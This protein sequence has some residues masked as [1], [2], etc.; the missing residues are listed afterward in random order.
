MKKN[1]KLIGGL[2]TLALMGVTNVYAQ[3]C[4][5]LEARINEA[6][7]GSTVNA[8]SCDGN[9]SIRNNIT[10]DLYGSTINTSYIE[11]TGDVKIKDS[12]GNGKIVGSTSGS[13]SAIGVEGKLTL[14]SGEIES[15]EFAILAT[16]GGS[17]TVNGGS[18]KARYA[19]LSGN[20]T[21]GAMEFVVNG[22]EITSNEGPAVYMP[23]PISYTMTGGKVNGGLL[24]R[25]GI[26]NVSGGNIVAQENKDKLD[27]LKQYYNFSGYVNYPDAISVIA[28]TYNTDI[29]G[30]TNKLEM[31][32][33]GGELS[34]N[35]GS[36]I[37]I[38]DFGK[39][40]QE[41]SVNI[42]GGSFES[43]NS[44]RKAYQIL[45]LNDLGV[46]NPASG[47]NNPSFMGDVKTTIT[48]GSFN[49]DVSQFI[50]EDYIQENGVVKKKEEETDKPFIP[51]GNLIVNAPIIESGKEVDVITVG[52][53]NTDDA[54]NAFAK[55]IES[56]GIDTENK[57]VSVDVKVENVKEIDIIESQIQNMKEA[58][59]KN[60]PNAKVAGYFDITL[61]LLEME[62]NVELGTLTKLDNKVKFN[63]A[64]PNDL[65]NVQG[66]YTRTYYIVRFHDNKSEIITANLN[67]DKSSVSFETDKF[68]TY[69]LIYKDTKEEVSVPKTF[70][71]ISSYLIIGGISL[72]S[73]FGL[74]KFLK[75]RN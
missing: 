70:D 5:S 32:I 57:K 19:A 50:G 11:I 25:M 34:S 68:S 62:N 7:A 37:A 63:I 52:L 64:L 2:A 58:I 44:D 47:Y 6:A 72:L 30:Q 46:T 51:G 45:T 1:L 56:L 16:N 36:A 55:A 27:D 54:K 74:T 18:V 12:L 21:L 17:I 33:T 38:Y 75:K 22:G 53:D 9:F 73:V 41:K 31:N 13:K 26:I 39:I 20:N 49:S 71:G 40:A 29:P 61:K 4:S 35:H 65:K 24:A 69:A 8:E 42:Q 28:G 66:G 43:S 3:D 67:D 23:G 14:E 48:G 15:N 59:E 10:L 60:Q